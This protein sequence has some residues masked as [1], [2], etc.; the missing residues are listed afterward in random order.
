VLAV[1]SDGLDFPGMEV[2]S[3][4]MG[5]QIMDHRAEMIDGLLN[6][7][8]GTKGGTMVT[9]EFPSEKHSH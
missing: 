8:K 3:A 9:C 4:G 5:L 7:R 1:E 2:K 6:I